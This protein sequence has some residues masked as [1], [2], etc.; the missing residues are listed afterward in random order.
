[1]AQTETTEILPIPGLGL[2]EIPLVESLLTS[3]GIWFYTSRGDWEVTLPHVFIRV[4]DRDL[5]KEFLKDVHVRGPN[6]VVV[7]IPW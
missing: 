4:A 2:G 6:E 5:V 1:M 7:P 3:A